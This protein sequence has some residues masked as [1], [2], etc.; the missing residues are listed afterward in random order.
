[1]K[2]LREITGSK[3]DIPPTILACMSVEDRALY[4]PDHAHATT[5][6]ITSTAIVEIPNK[7]DVR[8]EKFLQEEF[9]QWLLLHG[10]FYYRV[11][12]HKR[13]MLPLGY[14]DFTVWLGEAKILWIEYK[15]ETGQLSPEQA[16]YHRQL[17][18]RGHVVF[19]SRSLRFSIDC[20]RAVENAS[21]PKVAS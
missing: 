8:A 3:V 2:S 7:A 10:Y 1:M 20:L 5:S 13:S 12:M 9:E 19:T 16:E 21:A 15:T 4:A 18:E 6:A 11:P 17:Q 14:P